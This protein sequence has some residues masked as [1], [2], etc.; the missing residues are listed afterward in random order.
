MIFYKKRQPNPDVDKKP[1]MIRVLLDGDCWIGKTC[2]RKRY[3][4]DT[5]DTNYD[6]TIGIDFG[7]KKLQ[8][9]EHELNLD[10]WEL[11]GASSRFR[12]IT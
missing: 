11:V 4:D 9:E 10:V 1:H 5:F 2:V 12:T 3:V 6:Q 7:K 8:I